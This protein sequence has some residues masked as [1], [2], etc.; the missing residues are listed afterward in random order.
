MKA[1]LTLA[2]TLA[3]AA[4]LLAQNYES[5]YPYDPYSSA[6]RPQPR[7][8]ATTTA[9]APS[10][11]SS[12]GYDKLLSY[13]SLGLNYS[14]HDFRHDSI[15]SGSN[16][17]AAQLRVPLFKPLFLDF[18]VDWFRGTDSLNRSFDLTGLSG[19]VGVYL[20]VASQFHIYGEVGG[21]Y[22]VSGGSFSSIQANKAT[23]FFR[24]GV[25]IALSDSFE[26]A[27][28]I[29][30]SDASNFNNR[31]FEVNAY[32]ALLSVLDLG[33]GIDFATDANSYHAGLRLR[34]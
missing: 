25:R 28:G 27:G 2:L 4:P 12:Y 11:S 31:I 15:F 10:P 6:P 13:G 23:I 14:F 8:Y 33:F 16:G 30:F 21:R 26:L 29:N 34:W 18:G 1:V 9:P 5:Q 7:S 22:D 19:A 3:A 20:P 24:P 17:L 32:Y